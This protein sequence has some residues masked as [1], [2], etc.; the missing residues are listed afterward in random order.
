MSA[1]VSL[2]RSRQHQ[3]L[4]EGCHRSHPPHWVALVVEKDSSA[5]QQFLAER[6]ARQGGVNQSATPFIAPNEG[7]QFGK[8][9]QSRRHRFR[10]PFESELLVGDRLFQA[11]FVKFLEMLGIVGE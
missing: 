3:I 9:Q 7:L 5:E 6:D 11:R 10:V 4:F 8:V 1:K 2:C